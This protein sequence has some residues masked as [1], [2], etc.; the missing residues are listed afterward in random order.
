ML[1]GIFHLKG[2]IHSYIFLVQKLFYMIFGS[3][4]VSKTIWGI[5]FQEFLEFCYCHCLCIILPHSA[6]TW[7]LNPSY[8]LMRARVGS[9][10]RFDQPTHPPPPGSWICSYNIVQCPHP[11]CSRN[12]CGVPTLTSIGMCGVPPPCFSNILEFCAVSPP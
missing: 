9:K 11:N 6:R 1:E 2:G 7:I 8:A 5:K 3:R 12:L 10:I 4:G